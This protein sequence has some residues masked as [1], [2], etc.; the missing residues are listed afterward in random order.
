MKSLRIHNLFTF[1]FNKGKTAGPGKSPAMAFGALLQK[2][3]L[4]N[5]SGFENNKL[6]HMIPE[7]GETL[8]GH[9][10]I[11]T[12][13]VRQAKNEPIQNQTFFG[14]KQTFKQNL[15]GPDKNQIKASGQ[16]ASLNEVLISELI[17]CGKENHQNTSKGEAQTVKATA[18]NTRNMG[19][20]GSI[21]SKQITDLIADVPKSKVLNS[22]APSKNKISG[23]QN[24]TFP[25]K[26]GIHSDGNVVEKSIAGAK[27][28]PGQHPNM[29]PVKGL[30][31]RQS[32]Q[33]AIPIKE[34]NEKTNPAELGDS[35]K[36]KQGSQEPNPIVA[37]DKLEVIPIKK[38]IANLFSKLFNFKSKI[39]SKVKEGTSSSGIGINEK[40]LKPKFVAS[41]H[42]KAGQD[43]DIEHPLPQRD[44]QKKLS[45]HP[46]VR[47]EAQTIKST[48][49]AVKAGD[50]SISSTEQ[51]SAPKESIL[52]RLL[53]K[54]FARQTTIEPAHQP[55]ESKINSRGE[56][57]R[58]ESNS[59]SKSEGHTK[60][61]NV[62][63]PG[64][65]NS[66]TN[67]P[68]PEAGEKNRSK[69]FP[70]EQLRSEGRALPAAFTQFGSLPVEIPKPAPHLPLV[71]RILQF[72]VTNHNGSVNQAVLKINSA[73]LGKMEIHFKEVAK[74]KE[75]TLIVENESAKSEVERLLP[76]INEALQQRG[77]DLNSLKVD[78]YNY[79]Q[80]NEQER[81]SAEKPLHTLHSNQEEVPDEPKKSPVKVRQYGY[82]T[83][84][85][86]A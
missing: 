19:L 7:Q 18:M 16:I 25:V 26:S 58:I 70:A 35:G 23:K 63:L 21:Q 67:L 27:E 22:T 60:A 10:N 84:E 61:L 68:N 62:P 8:P 74:N 11:N 86:I 34:S 77:I 51:N 38:G 59:L 85:V 39:N 5:R 28:H 66:Q 48:P 6:S 42:V 30:K 52:Q 15:S 43:G 65:Q 13:I 56:H 78:L 44:L 12:E 83:I 41:P 72:V 46:V 29:I 57:G 55:T 14:T 4:K 20:E 37:V 49:T 17:P 82:N 32:T 76:R 50:C 69:G 80:K 53:Q 81:H 33:S 54:V 24:I 31:M 3:G 47:D 71:D 1:L 45:P 36:I 73:V 64:D 75:V 9:P 40:N 2:I 79:S